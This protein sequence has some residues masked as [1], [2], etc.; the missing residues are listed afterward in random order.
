MHSSTKV[1]YI[2]AT[3]QSRNVQQTMLHRTKFTAPRLSSTCHILR[4]IRGVW[5]ANS[6][7]VRMCNS[8]YWTNFV[9]CESY[10]GPVKEF[11]V[12]YSAPCPPNTGTRLSISSSLIL[13]TSM[14][15]PGVYVFFLRHEFRENPV[16]FHVH[17]HSSFCKYFI[18]M[19]ENCLLPFFCIAWHPTLTLGEVGSL[20][21]EA[22]TGPV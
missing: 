19:L 11:S 6:P 8:A 20:N 18:F 15:A 10:L 14:T 7:K 1:S 16:K 22:V 5:P 21:H 9:K 2:P 12:T 4:L 17:L 13:Q 3:M